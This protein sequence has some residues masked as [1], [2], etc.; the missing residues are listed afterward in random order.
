MLLDTK[1]DKILINMINQEA[2]QKKIG[3]KPHEHQLEVLEKLD[4]RI[5]VICAG[6]R[7]GKSA[8]CAYIALL[9]VL[10]PNKKIWIV[11][12]TYDLSQKVF[13]YLVR[14]FGKVAP[15]QMK[16]VSYRPFPRLK[17]AQSSLVECKSTENPTSLLGDEPDLIIIDEAARCPKRIWEAYLFP[18]T[19][20]R[21]GKAIMISTPKGKN[22]FYHQAIQARED[23]AFFTFPSNSNPTFKPE[24]WERAQKMLP[25]DVFSQEYK[26][27]FL[28]DA[29]SV[30]RGLDK[31]IKDNSLSDC[32]S[33]HY[34]VAGVDLGKHSDFTVIT[35]VDTYSNNVVYIDRFNDMDWNIQKARIKMAAERY[36]NARI[37]IDSTGIGDPISDDL[38]AK[39]LIIDDFRY[40][41]KSK[42]QLIE[43]L[44]IFIE[45]QL[46]NI[47]NND[48]LIDE[49][50]SFG[51]NMTDSGKIT[52]SAPSGSHDDMVNSLA[53]AVWGIMGKVHPV[54]AL[55]EQLKKGA[56]KTHKSIF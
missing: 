17:T 53:L 18:A 46:I 29:A 11:S 41:N 52:Y 33:G 38:K 7:F 39:G 19:A 43:K 40:T 50:Q 27:E 24:E 31:I 5:I 55:Q 49:L 54:T 35:V 9:A 47:P 30:F 3:W 28:D 44:S 8:I 16:G 4:K 13:N 22:W 36:N 21:Q 56:K 23:E 6:R 45:Q 26:A 25:Q 32:Q 14:W 12:P 51:Y 2:L 34:Y 42:Q 1:L 15:S 20:S 48:L 10:E 37:I